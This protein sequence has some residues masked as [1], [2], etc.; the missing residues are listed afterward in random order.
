MRCE[1]C[2]YTLIEDETKCPQCGTPVLV[3]EGPTPTQRRFQIF[4]TGFL[5]LMFLLTGLSAFSDWG[6]SFLTC[7]SIT[8]VLLLVRS[9]MLE[10]TSGHPSRSH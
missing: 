8:V 4:L 6:P 5:A 1:I 3:D 10:M 9:S 2:Q 7:A